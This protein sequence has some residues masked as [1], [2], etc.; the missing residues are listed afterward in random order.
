MATAEEIKKDKFE[1]SS[2][3]TQLFSAICFTGLSFWLFVSNGTK[4]SY[5]QRASLE[6]RLQV[7]CSIL[8]Y[9]ATL[10][11][12][13]NFFQ[14]TGADDFYLEDADNYS[15]D[16]ARPL[17]WIATCPLLQ[18]VLVL[19]GGTKIP[20]QR[21]I[22]QPLL[23]LLTLIGGLGSS[24]IGGPIRWLFYVFG[25]SC[26][27]ALFYFMARQIS[28]HSDGKESVFQGES[29]FR[30][31]SLIV[32]STWLPFPLW[33]IISP[34]GL[35]LVTNVLII[36]VGWCFLNI[37]AK[38]SMIFYIQRVKDGYCNR[39]KIKREIG[40]ESAKFRQPGAGDSKQGLGSWLQSPLDAQGDGRQM[41]EQSYADKK[42]A[43]LD[44]IVIDTMAHL[45][46]TQHV[47]RLQ[48]LLSKAGVRSI[49][50][51]DVL[52]E[53]ASGKLQLPWDL[54][55]ALRKRIQ[56]WKVELRD[57][58]ENELNRGE[59]FYATN[60]GHALRDP[61]AQIEARFEAWHETERDSDPVIA[62][63]DNLLI[64]REETLLQKMQE[65]LSGTMQQRMEGGLSQR[66]IRE[67][68]T[69]MTRSIQD[70][71]SQG[72]EQNHVSFAGI[73]DRKL[74]D[75]VTDAA[76]RAAERA[77]EMHARE[78][79]SRAADFYA[80]LRSH[81]AELSS[82]L[83]RKLDDVLVK[84]SK[85]I[86]T[87]VGQGVSKFS[88]QAE[89]IY[90][91]QM[92][93]LNK[94]AKD[95]VFE[96]IDRTSDRVK[97]IVSQ[98]LSTKIKGFHA[99]QLHQ[100]ADLNAD[101]VRKVEDM[102]TRLS[103][104]MTSTVL[105]EVSVCIEQGVAKLGTEVGSVCGQVVQKWSKDIVGSTAEVHKAT[106][107]VQSVAEEVHSAFTKFQA[108]AVDMKDAKDVV[109]EGSEA[110]LRE[111]KRVATETQRT[112]SQVAQVAS[113]LDEAI[114]GFAGTF[115]SSAAQLERSVGDRIE[116][117]CQ[118]IE[119]GPGA[120][121]V[122]DKVVKGL[123]GSMGQRLDSLR[124]A[125]QE[126]RDVSQEV[127][128][129][130]KEQTDVSLERIH[131]NT[132]KVVDLHRTMEQGLDRVLRCVSDKPDRPDYA[133]A[134]G[135]TVVSPVLQPETGMVWSGG[136]ANQQMQPSQPMQNMQSMPA[137]NPH[138]GNNERKEKAF[139]DNHG[140]MSRFP[141]GG[142]WQGRR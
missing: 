109:R 17:E 138:V 59:H 24:T 139:N 79:Q 91:G 46:M 127:G 29:E 94:D 44:S 69:S 35:N 47:E 54:I 64:A 102:L 86:G 57:N 48:T 19:I 11:A 83:T 26:A 42:Q 135:P 128:R 13:F 85:A 80:A 58:N 95:L 137:V 67:M 30:I 113:N 45:G 23:A 129:F 125:I 25:S 140:T 104:S 4:L 136:A 90:K 134:V 21:R 142:D 82:D 9:V 71:Q 81:H 88:Q 40:V 68:D 106:K 111:F 39:L 51:A 61:E 62:R 77:M 112:A 117:L 121:R 126:Q 92:Q 41:A 141:A 116:V 15:L 72:L 5:V 97:E 131:M 101:L 123:E 120:E 133:R 63:L 50:E 3:V 99:T 33:Y 12:F 43:Q 38:F 18:L 98:D 76:D 49:E 100:Q 27:V 36:Q 93:I 52:D 28:E 22:Q 31:A 6:K 10:S 130:V 14:L 87:E 65:M 55:S 16:L 118:H 115:K 119:G 8:T 105:E 1:E 74:E 2:Q 73:H 66:Q 34:E 124:N 132:G 107:E 75:L 37:T 20:E 122:V 110:T 114:N 84:A 103:S 32:M 53:R 70:K 60:P 56:V 78:A 7:S 108:A 89:Q 96:T